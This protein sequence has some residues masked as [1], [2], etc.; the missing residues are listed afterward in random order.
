[1]G[2]L[3]VACQTKGNLPLIF[4]YKISAT[5]FDDIEYRFFPRYTFHD[6]L[7]MRFPVSLGILLG[8]LI[9]IHDLRHNQALD[10][11]A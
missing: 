1:M 7:I 8:E 10:P 9:L 11:Q 2:D 5:S 4:L 6:A 3:S